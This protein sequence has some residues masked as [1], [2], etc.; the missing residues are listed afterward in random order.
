M[1]L[2]LN[3]TLYLCYYLRLNDKND[4]NRLAKDL[5]YFFTNNNF[6][7][8]PESEIKKITEQMHIE[9]SKGIALNRALRENLFTIFMCITNNVPL[10]IVGKPGTG[11]SLSFQILYN[12]L[13]GEYSESKMFKEKGKL[14][15][16][17][18]QGS[19][20]STSEGIQQVFDKALAAKKNSEKSKN[21]IITLVFFDEMGLAE[22][23]LNNPLKIIH[24]LLEKILKILFHS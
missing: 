3:M 12:T 17:Y 11:K 14:Y 18:Y 7:K 21:K 24:Y 16:Y 13:K 23:S 15:R 1:K 6:I 2:S 10:I 22:R 5:N 8:F 4:R 19:G 20:T 9:K